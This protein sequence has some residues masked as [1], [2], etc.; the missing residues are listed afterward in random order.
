M[1]GR[2]CGTM[3]VPDGSPNGPALRPILGLARGAAPPC[4]PG[5][6]EN[7]QQ[8]GVG[9]AR[10]AAPPCVP[11]SSQNRQRRGVGSRFLRF[12]VI[13]ILM[14]RPR[15]AGRSGW[16]YCLTR[17]RPTRSLTLTR[18]HGH[19]AA[20][21]GG[22]KAGCSNLPVHD[23]VGFVDGPLDWVNVR[24]QN[25]SRAAAIERQDRTALS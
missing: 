10:G 17:Y 21:D 23:D 4:V 14:S 15:Q 18:A 16:G 20:A 12:L 19:F 7:R 24:E 2:T 25:G 11:G 13:V 8:R 3:M 9:L 22:L 5:S 1:L 6:P